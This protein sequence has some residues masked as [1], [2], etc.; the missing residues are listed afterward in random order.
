MRL[1]Y[2][3]VKL[4]EAEPLTRGEY[5]T[6][7][8]WGVPSDGGPTDPGYLV[9]YPDGYES[10][11]PAKQFE[12]AYR[13]TDRLNFGLALEAAKKGGRI[14]RC[15]WNGRGMFVFL[16]KGAEDVFELDHLCLKTAEGMY[17]IG[18]LASQTD[19]LADDWFLLE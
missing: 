5:N 16:R 6:Y 10:W 12:E 17:C 2:L 18:W 15:G 9:V 3:G 4:I 13:K 19:M 11:S 8:G 7:R 1:K 14:T